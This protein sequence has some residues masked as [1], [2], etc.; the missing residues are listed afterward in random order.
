MTNLFGSAKALRRR[1]R[2]SVHAERGR[3]LG[4]ASR[5][6]HSPTIV[7]HAQYVS[8]Q[9]EPQITPPPRLLRTFVHPLVQL[10]AH[11]PHVN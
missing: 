7:L 10:V 4:V 11:L 3:R 2:G 6:L 9:Q 1:R 8:Q 5:C